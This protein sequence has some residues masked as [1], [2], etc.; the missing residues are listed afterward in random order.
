FSVDVRSTGR[1]KVELR[2]AAPGG[3]VIEETSF[4]VRSTV[5]NRI[6]LI[7][8]VVAGVALVAMWARRLWRRR[9]A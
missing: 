8:T 2:V 3:R 1:F 4:V 5:Y 9:R 7:I 6:A